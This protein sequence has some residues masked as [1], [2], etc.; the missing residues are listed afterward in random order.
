MHWI[1]PFLFLGLIKF[2]AALWWSVKFVT[3]CWGASW[4]QWCMGTCR[5]GCM[6][7]LQ[8]N[9]LWKSALAGPAD[10]FWSYF[11][12]PLF[13]FFFSKKVLPNVN[14]NSIWNDLSFTMCQ[15]GQCPLMPWVPLWPRVR[16]RS[17]WAACTQQSVWSQ[18]PENRLGNR[19]EPYLYP[20]SHWA[21][22]PSGP[23]IW[24][25]QN[26]PA[27]DQKRTVPELGQGGKGAAVFQ[28]N[29]FEGDVGQALLLAWGSGGNRHWP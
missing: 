2:A 27:I 10:P 15:T 23:R 26:L 20:A 13:F 8:S 16:R 6:W 28:G 19:L 17:L 22:Q 4:G 5:A 24:A 12:H 11:L 7:T 14:F 25:F 18:K 1:L 21:G 3:D 29:A 9:D